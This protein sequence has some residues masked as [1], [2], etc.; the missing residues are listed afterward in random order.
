M[1]HHGLE[2]FRKLAHSSITSVTSRCD[3]SKRGTIDHKVLD[4][5]HLDRLIGP[6]RKLSSEF[7]GSD[8]RVDLGVLHVRVARACTISQL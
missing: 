7:V 3:T 2:L 6:P 4:I 8:S 5:P 1:G